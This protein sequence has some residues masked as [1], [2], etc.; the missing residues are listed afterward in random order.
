MQI[1]S[2]AQHSG[3]G[4]WHCHSF[5]VGPKY[6]SDLVPGLETPYALGQLKMGKKKKKDNPEKYK[7]MKITIPPS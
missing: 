4:I 2:P 7:K 3:L 5:S 1:Q 6:S